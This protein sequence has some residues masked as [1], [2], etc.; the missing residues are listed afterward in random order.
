[1]FEA[2]LTFLELCDP[3]W[4]FAITPLQ[5][6]ETRVRPHARGFRPWRELAGAA[7]HKFARAAPRLAGARNPGKATNLAHA[8]GPARAADLG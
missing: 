1:V 8:S 7:V 5:R 3:K 2:K 6:S 4:E